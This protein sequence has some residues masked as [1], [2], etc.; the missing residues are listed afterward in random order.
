M[1]NIRTALCAA[2][3]LGP[4]PA[5]ANTMTWT[6]TG[7]D[8][9]GYWDTN[10]AH[11]AGV[12][13]YPFTQNELD[14]LDHSLGPNLHF[15][16]RVDFIYSDFFDVTG[17]F[18]IT[19]GTA[20]RGGA[21]DHSNDYV[22]WINFDRGSNYGTF[23]ENSITIAHGVITDWDIDLSSV[24]SCVAIKTQYCDR[25]S[26]LN[27]GDHVRSY[28]GITGGY[29]GADVDAPGSWSSVDVPG[30]VAGAGLPGLLMVGL[31]GWWR[32]RRQ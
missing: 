27:G 4:L 22:S 32:R 7:Q 15:T 17:T 29:F 8:Y 28:V 5:S 30:P 9:T 2:L 6:Y 16:V 18:I 20:A 21:M 31:F 24:S 19:N 25:H 1:M 26:S 13:T 14:A 3:V 11:W 10:I 12:I 23:F